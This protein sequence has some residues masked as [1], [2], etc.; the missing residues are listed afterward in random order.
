MRARAIGVLG[1]LITSVT[2]ITGRIAGLARILRRLRVDG[3]T[4]PYLDAKLV[5][6]GLGQGN[7]VAVRRLVSLRDGDR[8]QRTF[9]GGGDDVAAGMLVA[10]GYGHGTRVAGAR[11]LDAFGGADAVKLEVVNRARVDVVLVLIG[12][13]LAAIRADH[14]VRAAELGG[15]LSGKRIVHRV[16]EQEGSGDERSADQDGDACRNQHPGAFLHEFQSYGKHGGVLSLAFRLSE[17][18][19]R[20]R[21]HGAWCRFSQLGAME[22]R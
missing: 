2:G 19:G 20:R 17:R 14:V 21:G 6:Y 1:R 18:A 11:V 4:V 16:A 9:C 5:G 15:V 8:Q 3:H 13:V 12:Q 22:R 7:L 10:T